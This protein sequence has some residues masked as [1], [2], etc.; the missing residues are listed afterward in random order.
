[1]AGSPKK[2]ILYVLLAAAAVAVPALAGYLAHDRYLNKNWGLVEPGLYR[3]GLTYPLL[4]QQF[5]PPHKI[6]LVVSLLYRED[7]DPEQVAELRAARDLNIPFLRFPLAGAGMPA[8]REERI[9]IHVAP[10][11]R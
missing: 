4:T 7:S 9:D 11:D 8:G 5:L 10:V 3:S 2:T 6:A 1:M